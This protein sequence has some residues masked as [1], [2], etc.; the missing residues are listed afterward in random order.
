M[1]C[2]EECFEVEMGVDTITVSTQSECIRKGFFYLSL[3]L[4][5]KILNY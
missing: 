4:Q 2:V 5:L 1:F 3:A